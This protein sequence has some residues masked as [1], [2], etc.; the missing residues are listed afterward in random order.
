MLPRFSRS[1]V[2]CAALLAACGGG[3]DTSNPTAACNSLASTYCDKAKSCGANVASTCASNAQQV[4]GCA[5]FS[6]PAGT[7]FDSAAAKQCIDGINGWS[8]NED[9]SAI[10]N[11]T[12]PDACHTVCH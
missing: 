5:S 10:V 6:C 2:F 9:A 3:A 11:G 4:L 7:T 12:L 8:C 1:L